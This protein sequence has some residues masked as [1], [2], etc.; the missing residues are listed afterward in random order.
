MIS[1]GQNEL[2]AIGEV[3]V[4][5]ACLMA[6]HRLFGKAGLIAWMAIS[7]ILANIT[8]TKTVEI[9]GIVSTLGNTIYISLALCTDCINNIHGKREAKKAIWI[10]FASMLV[11]IAVT[12]LAL[13]FTPD[14]SDFAQG[15]LAA[16]FG[17]MPRIMAGSLLA[18]LCSSMIDAE[19]FALVRKK[20]PDKLWVRTLGS[21]AISQ[22]IDSLIFCTIAFWGLWDFNTWLQ[23]LVTTYLLK[24]AVYIL[25]TPL[26]SLLVWAQPK[27]E[28]VRMQGEAMEAAMWK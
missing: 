22:V 2:L 16:I 10:T 15:P 3:V 14:A 28:R 9:F 25:S 27:E 26:I 18:Y 8:V 11:M 21:T 12:Q 5:F 4:T 23:V 13:M 1:F 17:I 20:W 24:A 19:I 7:L 6:F